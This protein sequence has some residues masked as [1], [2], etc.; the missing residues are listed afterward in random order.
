V[1]VDP[2]GPPNA[3]V[4]RTASLNESSEW[5][6]GDTKAA[7][8]VPTLN[9]TWF[10]DGTHIY[11]PHLRYLYYSYDGRQSDPIHV[12]WLLSHGSCKPSETY[13][14]GF[15]YIFLFMVSIF[16]FVWSCIMIG[17]WF[18]TSRASRVYKSGRRPGLLKSILDI[19]DAIR[20]ELGEDVDKLEEENLRKALN[21]SGG[22]LVVPRRELKV[23][24]TGTGVRK[25]GW[26]RNLT[27]GSTF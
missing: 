8:D 3:S 1:Q 17:M 2:V 14:W 27:Q 23:S 15:S 10:G 24:R 18:D 16:N 20:E 22:A 4:L 13:Q 5:N 6:F 7:L 21:D 19:S 9:I 12:R 26:K 25:R 11:S